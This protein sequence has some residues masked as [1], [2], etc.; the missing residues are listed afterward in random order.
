MVSSAADKPGQPVRGRRDH[1]IANV[2]ESKTDLA[3]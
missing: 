1:H 3:N 2:A